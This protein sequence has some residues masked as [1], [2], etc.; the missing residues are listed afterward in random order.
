MFKEGDKI[1]NE[2]NEE[3]KKETQIVE[4]YAAK[5][6]EHFSSVQIFVTKHDMAAVDGTASITAGSGNW[7]ARYGQVL[8]WLVRMN[9]AEENQVTEQ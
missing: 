4:N 2:P 8:A 9:K 7:Y 6:A 3:R 1:S 5:L